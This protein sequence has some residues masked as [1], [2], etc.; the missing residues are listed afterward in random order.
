MFDLESAQSYLEINYQ[1]LLVKI[2]GFT[3]P[4]SMTFANRKQI[5]CFIN[6]RLVSD[7]TLTAAIIRAYYGY[8][9]VGRFPSTIL[10]I[11]ISPAEIDVNVHP[12]KDEIRFRDSGQIFSVIHSAVRQ[13]ISNMSPMPEFFLPTW[14]S[15]A[16][17]ERRIDPGW[18]FARAEEHPDMLQKPAENYP[19]SQPENAS[20]GKVPIL[21]L[22]G[23]LGRTYLA[24]EGPDGLYLI[25]QHAA[26]E[27][28]LFERIQNLPQAEI[29]SQYLLTP[30]TLQI[31]AR[32]KETFNQERD[33]LEKIGF[34][35]EEFGLD[36]IRITA[37][38]VVIQKMNPSEALMGALEPEDH[39]NGLVEEEL[40]KRIILK[41]CKKAA[42][43]GGQVLS[44]TEQEQ[45]IRDL[46]NCSSPRTC[47]HGRPTMIHLSVDL[48]ERQ[49]GRLGSR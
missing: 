8:L 27:R 36:T 48:L 5:F 38:P 33:I 9:M 7:A 49:F 21:R 23:Q 34:R 42:I 6:G 29:I 31:P 10:F 4:L 32:L 3:S 43:K 14:N 41:I 30:E 28:I 37:L 39:Q 17:T 22:I 40:E 35:F 47:P 45:L 18:D 2:E 26:H 12:T 19:P 20:L 15:G 24:A 25:D 11:E 1:N 16:S 46:E 13:T 44:V